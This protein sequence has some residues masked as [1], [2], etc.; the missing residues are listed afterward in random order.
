MTAE[1]KWLTTVNINGVAGIGGLENVAK[2]KGQARQLR[3][4][5]RTATPCER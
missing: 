2:R 4:V 5:P 1:T 3:P